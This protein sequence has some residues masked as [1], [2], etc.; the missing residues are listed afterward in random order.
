MVSLVAVSVGMAA[1]CTLALWGFN[2][3]LFMKNKL[4]AQ[5]EAMRFQYLMTTYFGQAI[6]VNDL[7]PQVAGTVGGVSNANYDAMV[8]N[9]AQLV[10]SFVRDAGGR[11]RIPDINNVRGD[12]RDTAIW[13]RGPTTG[14]LPNDRSSGVIFFDG[15]PGTPAPGG[16]L[17]P[18]YN[19]QYVGRMTEFQI[20]R[21][22]G[23]RDN[24]VTAV[25]VRAVFRYMRPGTGINWCPS[26]D[27][28]DGT[29]N[30]AIGSTVFKD[31]ETSFRIVLRNN[32]ISANPLT[33][34]GSP[35]RPLG[36]IYFFSPIV[37]SDWRL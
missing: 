12:Y 27:I 36:K 9:T 1:L 3:F 20:A 25:R 29:A 6:N 34:G 23:G 37:P 31:L 32:V 5:S 24:V 22:I 26:R 4:E 10:A 35:E 18:G 15:N 30:C 17:L 13:W 11:G 8:G 7:N 19:D 2:E 28:S 14:A 21:E 16:A 33:G